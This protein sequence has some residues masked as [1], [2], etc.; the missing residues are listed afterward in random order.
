MNLFYCL[1][2]ILLVLLVAIGVA[3]CSSPTVQMYSK[4]VPK[5]DLAT[6]FNGDIDAYGIFTDR[7]GEV[8]KRFKVVIK[9]KW[10][11]KDGKRVGVLDEDFTYSDGTKQKR[12]WTLNGALAPDEIFRNGKRCDWRSRWRDGR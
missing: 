11:M 1:K 6:Y 3:S 7:S 4:E 2:N 10:E 5:L 9:A 12:I 8:V